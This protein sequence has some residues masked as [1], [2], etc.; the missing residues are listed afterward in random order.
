MTKGEYWATIT[1][2][3]CVIDLHPMMSTMDENRIMITVS[4]LREMTAK[5]IL[6]S[7]GIDA[8]SVNKLDSAHAGIF[9]EIQIYVPKDKAEEAKNLLKA[10]GILD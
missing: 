5:H 2:F 3:F 8:V 7:A 4:P 10:E 1:P 9:G 6:E